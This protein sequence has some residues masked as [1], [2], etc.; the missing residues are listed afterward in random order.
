MGLR[1]DINV[2]NW[3]AYL[4]HPDA[5][6]PPL[7]RSVSEYELLEALLNKLSTGFRSSFE[8]TKDFEEKISRAKQM[9]R[10]YKLD[11]RGM[12]HRV[13]AELKAD[14][15]DRIWTAL[16]V[17]SWDNRDL[18]RFLCSDKLL[19][20]LVEPSEPS[21][22]SDNFSGLIIQLEQPPQRESSFPLTDVFPLFKVALN[23]NHEW[24]GLLVW[25]N[26]N[27]SSFF[28]IPWQE[29]PHEEKLAWYLK[30]LIDELNRKINLGPPGT[31]ILPQRE[32][33]AVSH[34]SDH[35]VHIIQ[36]SDIHLG[37]KEA[38]K[39][40]PQL[41]TWIRQLSEELAKTGLVIPIVTGDL[42]NTNDEESVDRAHLFM[43][44][45]S[46]LPTSRPKVLLG[47]HDVRAEGIALTDFT[48]SMNIFA[49]PPGVYWYED[50]KLALVCFNSVLG[51]DLARGEVTERQIVY[52]GNKL[53]EKPDWRDYLIVAAL[54][55]HPL[56][57]DLPEW[58]VRPFYERIFGSW[59]GITDKLVDAEIFVDFVE[60]HDMGLVV[61]GHK[62]I[63]K[64][65]ETPNKHIPIF[66]CGSSVGK[67]K[68]KSR[69]TYLSLNVLTIDTR[70]RRVTGR[71]LAQPLGG[72]DE[73]VEDKDD[74]FV[75]RM[76]RFL[77]VEPLREQQLIYRRVM[78]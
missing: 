16:I 60:N 72:G 17:P 5:T 71:L 62:H 11:S 76:K 66:A 2:A 10:R 53:R 58:Y 22:S 4:L 34:Y 59:F 1:F 37:T 35:V 6:T 19:R 73:H 28:P 57:M 43:D 70:A 77:G 39:R 52:L 44:F 41:Q 13:L 54:H 56:K 64:I 38:G 18:D 29:L 25:T 78:T 36:A 23:N 20:R 75:E 48:A 27:Q 55:H 69:K 30:D 49:D 12:A 3:I 24:P 74:W 31:P 32:D 47:N 51:G 67:I 8:R 7:T 63:P 21:E 61:H 45:L 46:H 50:Q 33:P 42:M 68:R 26:R 15:N 65:S 14:L 40:L 9:L